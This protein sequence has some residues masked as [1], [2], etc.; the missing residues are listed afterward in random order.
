ML[1]F[2]LLLICL[3]FVCVKIAYTSNVHYLQEFASFSF[4][5]ETKS[6]FLETSAKMGTNVNECVTELAKMLLQAEDDEKKQV[7]R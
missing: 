7:G 5:Q 3:Q 6:K 2:R 1:I 4:S